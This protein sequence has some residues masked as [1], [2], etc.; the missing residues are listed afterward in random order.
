ME[1]EKRDMTSIEAVKITRNLLADVAIPAKYMEQ[2]SVIN[3]ACKNLDVIEKMIE[4]ELK[5]ARHADDQDEQ[6]ENVP[7]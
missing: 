4:N 3:A 7:G 5:E 1:T 6:G 2:I